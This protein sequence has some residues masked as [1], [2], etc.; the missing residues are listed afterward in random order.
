MGLPLSDSATV[1]MGIKDFRAAEA[2]IDRLR[3]E[4]TEL[5]KN[6][7]TTGSS[8]QVDPVRDLKALLDASLP[9]VQFAVGHL[10]PATVRDWPHTQLI[11][12]ATM[13]ERLYPDDAN[14]GSLAIEF[15]TFASEAARIAEFRAERYRAAAAH[16]EGAVSATTQLADG[17][18]DAKPLD[19][20]VI[21]GDN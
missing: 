18:R 16:V 9:I 17:D 1:T 14:L 7:V 3:V 12:V 11:A 8:E 6:R 13:I 10:D 5:R 20:G 19:S 21:P 4:N 15:R 2:E